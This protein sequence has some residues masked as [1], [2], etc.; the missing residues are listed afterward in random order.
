MPRY[1]SNSVTLRVT[2]ETGIRI[3]RAADEKLPRSAALS[4]IAIASRRSNSLAIQVRR[5]ILRILGDLETTNKA[6]SRPPGHISRVLGLSIGLAERLELC[7]P[8]V[9][10]EFG[11]CRV[12]GIIARQ[13]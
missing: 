5:L 11:P 7:E 4:S 12:G 2:V 13:V 1:S 6:K 8:S 10:H 9:Y 3:S